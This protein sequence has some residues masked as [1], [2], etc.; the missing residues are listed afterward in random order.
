[1]TLIE[2]L[3]QTNQFHDNA[4][5]ST[6]E[7]VA[8]IESLQAENERL[9]QEQAAWRSF[10]EMANN[11]VSKAEAER[12]ALA[13]KLVPLTDKQRRTLV[14]ENTHMDVEGYWYVDGTMLI[15]AVEAAHGIQAKGGQQ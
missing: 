6:Q 9:I 14:D 5:V 3:N 10:T 8:A 4:D 13:A 7:V 11:T 1:M 15:A 12:D 2:R